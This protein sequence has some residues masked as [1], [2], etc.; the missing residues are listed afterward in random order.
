LLADKLK[1]VGEGIEVL[2]QE[3]GTLV[4]D[5]GLVIGFGAGDITYQLRGTV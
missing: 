1:R 5:K 2:K 3:H 4:L